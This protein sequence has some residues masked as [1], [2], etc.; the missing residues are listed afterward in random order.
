MSRGGWERV[1]LGGMKVYIFA[2]VDDVVLIVEK[3]DGMKSMIGKLE[4]YLEKK[5]LVLNVEKSKI[6]RFR[7]RGGR[8]RKVNWRWKRKVIE[9]K[10][11]EGSAVMGQVWGI[12]K[13]KF[14][15]DW[16]RR[17]WLFNKLVWTVMGYGIE[18]WG[19]GERKELEKLQE[20]Y[21]RWMLGVKWGT[22][23]YM[24]REELQREKLR[25]RA[26]RRGWRFEKRLEEGRGSG[27]ARR[28]WEKLRER[29]KRKKDLLKWEEERYKFFEDSGI[30]MR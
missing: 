18:I 11:K 16:G 20:K 10:I 17:L 5:G 28:C 7:K 8:E 26:G 19:W 9:V 4:S 3:E 30:G 21:L 15:N 14:K 6:L 2:Y 1:K 12:G 22:T 24:V 27:I 25:G 13:R 29:S 23:G